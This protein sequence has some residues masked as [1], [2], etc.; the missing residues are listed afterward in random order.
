MS[1]QYLIISAP[2]HTE[3]DGLITNLWET[4]YVH[5]KV[6]ETRLRSLISDVV[7]KKVMWFLT[8]T[9]EGCNQHVGALPNDILGRSYVFLNKSHKAMPYLNRPWK[10]KQPV[11][12]WLGNEYM[13]PPEDAQS[14]RTVDTC[15]FPSHI[16]ETGKVHFKPDPARKDWK[17]LSTRSL[18]PSLIV[19]ATGYKQDFEWLHNSYPRAGQANV[20]NIV[21]SDRPDIAFI[22]F[23][24]PG[25]GAIPPIAEQQAMW[26]VALITNQMAMPTTAGHYR[27]LTKNNA[28]IEYGVDYSTYMSV[29]ALDFGGAPSIVDLWSIHGLRIL[30]AYCFGASFVSF[31]RLTGPFASA[32]AAQVASTELLD[33]IRRRGIIGN[34]FFGVVPMLFYGT[35]NAIAFLLEKLGVL[36]AEVS[37]SGVDLD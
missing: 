12:D 32:Y 37:T 30:F 16:D 13:D 10:Q 21:K 11:L 2:S 31:Y 20:R 1:L 29:L 18:Y 25:V 9:Q 15:T 36:S 35:L 17:R 5:H 14:S 19:Y 24:R 27:L 6:R 8:G 28:R 4:A 23:V 34:F 7:I 33:T 22:G 26:W 3:A